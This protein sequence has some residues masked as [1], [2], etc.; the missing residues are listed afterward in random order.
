RE[1]V[2]ERD[3]AAKACFQAL[4]KLM[5]RIAKEKPCEPKLAAQRKLLSGLEEIATASRDLVKEI[6][7]VFKFATRLID[8]AEKD[9]NARAHEQW[10]GRAIGRLEKELEARR[11][12]AVEQLKAAAYFER[13]AHWLLS[14]FPDGK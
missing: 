8:A 12:D 3:D 6:D 5:G 9:A 7:L 13:Q 4:D 2:T 11:K 10:D 1:L 14:R